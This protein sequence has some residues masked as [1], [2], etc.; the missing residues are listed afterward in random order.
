[1]KNMMQKIKR[2][3]ELEQSL[4]KDTK[5]KRVIDAEYAK[6]ITGIDDPTDPYSKLYPDQSI[7][8]YTKLLK[9][10]KHQDKR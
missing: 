1:M 3:R 7:K 9:R 2:I 6:G 8:F 4:G 5:N 10:K